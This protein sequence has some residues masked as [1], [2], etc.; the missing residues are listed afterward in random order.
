MLLK[1][2]IAAAVGYG[3]YRYATTNPESAKAYSGGEFGTGKV[4]P[5]DYASHNDLTGVPGVSPS[6]T[7]LQP[8]HTSHMS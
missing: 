6:S 1:L 2:G 4:D 8:S 5:H 3:I 7:G